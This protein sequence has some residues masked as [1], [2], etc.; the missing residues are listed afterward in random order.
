YCRQHGLTT[1]TF[2]RWLKYLAG[3]EAARKHA[4]YQAELRRQQRR[5]AQEKRRRRRSRFRFGVSTDMRSRALQAFWAMHVEAMNWSGMSVREYAAALHLSPTSLRKWRDRLDDG[6][7]DIDW[8]AH[9]HPSARPVAGT[10]ANRMPPETALTAP[11]RDD[12][13]PPRQPLRRFFTDEQKRAIALESDQPGVSVSQVA[14]KHGIVAG[15]LFR[16]RVQ[17]GVAQAKRAKLAPVALTD[18]ATAIVRLRD[19]VQPPDG[20]TA[21]DLPDGRRVFA[22]AGVDPQ[23]VREHAVG[24]GAAP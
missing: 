20:M 17:F 21:I 18:D 14:R 6:E 24:E 19:L 23:A 16:W 7:V 3:K 2:D 12:P 11:P 22:P 4:E 10:S 1:T 9:L 15:L 5:E 8:R 13:A